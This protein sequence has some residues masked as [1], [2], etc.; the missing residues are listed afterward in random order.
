MAVSKREL[1]LMVKVSGKIGELTK[2]VR[3]MDKL[4]KTL[5]VQESQAK[6][7][8]KAYWSLDKALRSVHKT[9]GK[10]VGGLMF[11]IPTIGPLLGIIGQIGSAF[12]SL[13][14]VVTKVFLKIAKV[15][16]AI[17]KGLIRVAAGI[18]SAIAR[19]FWGL[20]RT[21]TSAIGK[22]VGIFGSIFGR[23]LGV[24]KKATLAMGIA[25]AAFV[26]YAIHQGA[27]F[28]QKMREIWTLMPRLSKAGMQ[29]MS[30]NV[31]RM[32]SQIP[33]TAEDMA[34]GLYKVVSSGFQKASDA[35]E[36]MRVG[37]R[38]AV[39]GVTETELAIDALIS[40]LL[41]YGKG[42]GD[43]K[44]AGDILFKT[45]EQAR[46]T[47]T[48]LSE[49]IGMVTGTAS[50]MKLSWK[51]M[52]ASISVISRVLKPDVTFV[53]L[54]RLL[55]SM[56]APAKGAA[57]AMK[58]YGFE[59]KRAGDGTLDMQATMEGLRN[60]VSKLGVDDAA[61]VLKKMFPNVRALRGVFAFLGQTT[62][63]VDSVFRALDDS[64]GSLD[65]AFKKMWG[66][67]TSQLKILWNNVSRFGKEFFTIFAD[68]ISGALQEVNSWLSD[69]NDWIQELRKA[70]VFENMKKSFTDFVKGMKESNVVK[71]L[72]EQFDNLAKGLP[73]TFGKIKKTIID[74]FSEAFVFVLSFDWDAFKGKA[75]TALIGIADKA[76]A[77]GAAL[78]E[79]FRSALPVIQAVLNTALDMVQAVIGP[80]LTLGKAH[81]QSRAT[82][83][84][85]RT[86]AA[87]QAVA[88]LG[89]IVR[90]KGGTEKITQMPA[91]GP[92]G[93]G[94]GV[95][96]GFERPKKGETQSDL[97]LSQVAEATG[98]SAPKALSG[99]P[100]A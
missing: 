84:T 50:A 83:A 59:I 93:G 77:I 46:M 48:D 29:T 92:G 27:K 42:A 86:A 30:D 2:F 70:K 20:V 10:G 51:G 17:L 95:G 44:K 4:N 68:D 6:K 53:A 76:L 13:V 69:M 38:I 57:K 58:E 24:V 28:E 26:V 99:A 78:I 89:N 64:A 71:W 62:S 16:A 15:A 19:L 55:L 37:A 98:K 54:N 33:K 8:A 65:K 22:L 66:S 90:T 82:S 7:T 45:L 100:C 88:S 14:G 96:M 5:T 18:I 41:A 39:A 74:A 61:R 47:F 9:L 32:S 85:S 97:I 25:F 12:G 60:I 34:Q 40:K 23:V 72:Q 36:I 67:V 94:P 87:G 56:V 73:T 63:Q 3:Q 75:I 43:A 1:Q 52:G 79:G 80:L 11:K 35:M 21:V 91:F 31:L 49:G 81:Y